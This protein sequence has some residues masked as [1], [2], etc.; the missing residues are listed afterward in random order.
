MSGI[1]SARWFRWTLVVVL[2]TMLLAATMVPWYLWGKPKTDATSQQKAQE[3]YGLATQSGMNVPSVNTLEQ[4][5]GTDGGYGAEVAQSSLREASLLYTNSSTGEIVK[6]PSLAQAKYIA[7]SVL[8]LKVYRP[9]LY[10]D[11]VLPYIKGLKVQDESK[12]PDWLKEDLA[13]LP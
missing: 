6:R 9:D 1:T 7:Y 3:L 11:T 5:Y 12:Y 8:V 4:I 2:V 10:W 13:Q